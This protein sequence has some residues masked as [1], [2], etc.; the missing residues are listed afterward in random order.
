MDKYFKS[1]QGIFSD[2]EIAELREMCDNLTGKHISYITDKGN[3]D[4]NY[5]YVPE[6]Q[7]IIQKYLDK[8]EQKTWGMFMYH[9]PYGKVIRHVDD[10]KSRDCCLLTPLYD[11]KNIAPCYFYDTYDETAPPVA[12]CHYEYGKSTLINT[13]EIHNLENNEN[14]RHTFQVCFSKSIMDMHKIFEKKYKV[15]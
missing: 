6:D 7:S 8:F 1:Y 14:E 11:V 5:I 10:A 15:A 2:Q 13:Q 9:P 12:T 3:T 4:G